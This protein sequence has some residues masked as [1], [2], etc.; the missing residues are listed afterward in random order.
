MYPTRTCKHEKH[1]AG[2]LSCMGWANAWPQ[3]FKEW[4]ST[5]RVPVHLHPAVKIQE[6]KAWAATVF[7]GE[8]T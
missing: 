2:C 8:S 1:Q 6:A 7:Q 3:A 5:I 4:M